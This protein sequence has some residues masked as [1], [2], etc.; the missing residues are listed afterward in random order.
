MNDWERF[1]PEDV[2]VLSLAFDELC[3][4][5]GF[6]QPSDKLAR[7]FAE[8]IVASASAG[9][10]DPLNI[11]RSARAVLARTMA[12]SHRKNSLTDA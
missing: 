1:T 6:T 8:I 3:D 9:D 11:A 2:H 5:T 4:L 10:R 7:H 12:L